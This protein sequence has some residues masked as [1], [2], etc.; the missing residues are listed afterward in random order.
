MFVL[1]FLLFDSNDL[2]LTF[3]SL[4]EKKKLS[5][6]CVSSYELN[7]N[8]INS[9]ADPGL[10]HLIAHF[11]AQFFSISKE[12]YR[13]S[14]DRWSQIVISYDFILNA[15]FLDRNRLQLLCFSLVLCFWL[16]FVTVCDLKYSYWMATAASG[17]NETTIFILIRDYSC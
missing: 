1:S 13:S 16:L 12:P 6:F 3:T 5:Y 2:M 15:L 10:I 7:K 9:I 11:L 8:L 14:K 17:L 4:N